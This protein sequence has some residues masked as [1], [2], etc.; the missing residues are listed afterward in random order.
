MRPLTKEEQK[1]YTESILKLYKPTGGNIMEDKINNKLKCK[2]K[3]YEERMK[4][5]TEEKARKEA[6][7]ETSNLIKEVMNSD[8]ND[9]VKVEI[10]KRLAQEQEPI[11]IPYV[12]SPENWWESRPTY[13]S[14]PTTSEPCVNPRYVYIGDPVEN[15]PH[16]VCESCNIPTGAEADGQPLPWKGEMCPKCNGRGMIAM[17]EKDGVTLK[18]LVRC[19]VC[20]GKGY[21]KN[22]ERTK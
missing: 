5:A 10:I 15:Q 18:G 14:N 4:E 16:T 19:S 21:V 17:G 3:S 13:V 7:L 11:Y 8:M 12:Q 1:K 20:G 22:K 2:R 9:D 6:K